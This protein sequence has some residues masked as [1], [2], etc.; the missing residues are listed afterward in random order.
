VSVGQAVICSILP[1]LEVKVEALSVGN[2]TDYDFRISTSGVDDTFKR[3]RA[4][5]HLFFPVAAIECDPAHFTA[6]TSWVLPAVKPLSLAAF[7][8]QRVGVADSCRRAFMRQWD[9]AGDDG[10]RLLRQ[11]SDAVAFQRQQF[12]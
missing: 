7:V 1:D 4:A 2:V 12:D 10:V 3:R 11:W 8:F 6:A 5:G 9:H